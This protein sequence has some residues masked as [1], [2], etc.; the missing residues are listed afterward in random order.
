MQKSCWEEKS[1]LADKCDFLKKSQEGELQQSLAEMENMRRQE[2]AAS[3]PLSASHRGSYS[4]KHENWD[5]VLTMLIRQRNEI[6]KYFLKVYSLQHDH[7][8]KVNK[9]NMT[10]LDHPRASIHHAD[11]F[12]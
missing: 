6:C 5:I 3:Q 2:P 8:M 1:H 9:E 12:T 4:F 10:P 7:Q 11:Y